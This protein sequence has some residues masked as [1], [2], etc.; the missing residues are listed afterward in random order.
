MA[1]PTDKAAAER[2]RRGAIQEVAA[3]IVKTSRGATDQ[4][5]AECTVRDAIVRQ[6][7]IERGG[8]R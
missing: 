4:R 2:T 1:G 7:R 5:Q 3:G 8:G 6:E